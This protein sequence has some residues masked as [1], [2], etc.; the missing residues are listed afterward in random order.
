MPRPDAYVGTVFR[1][2]YAERLDGT[3]PANEFF[4]NLPRQIK[5]RFGVSFKKLGDTGKLWN[6][7]HF[8]IVEG[9]A[10]YEFKVHHYRIFCRFLEKKIVLLTN[11]CEKKKNKL[12]K[13]DI[14]RAGRIYQEDKIK[15]EDDTNTRRQGN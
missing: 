5:N 15:F 7:E 1:V 9:T 14:D 8:K 6:K 4:D 2:A 12:D 11:G 3:H 13:E 10:F